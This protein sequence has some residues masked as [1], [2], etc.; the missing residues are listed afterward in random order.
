MELSERKIKI[1][2]IAVEEFIKDSAPITSG[3][4]LDRTSLDVSTATLR[5]ELNA[6]EAMGFL[7]QLHTS[8]GRVPTAQGY[9]FYVENLLKNIKATNGELEDVRK[10][11]ENRTQSLT[12]IVS[13]IAKIISKATNYPT[14]V[15]VNGIENL[16]LQEFKIIPLLDEKVMVLIGTNY[17]YITNTMDVKASAQNCED[18]SNYLTK[19][20]KGETMGFMLD[21]IDQ[22]KNGM[23]GEIEAFQG[24]VDNIIL[25]LSKMNKRKLLN[26]QAGG[27][28]DLVDNSK[29]EEAKKVLKTLSDENE[30][31]EV[32]DGDE[33]DISAVIAEDGEDKCS[34]VKAPIIVGGNKLASIGV[35][36][37]QK[38]D[39][40]GIASALKVV[41]DE[42]NKEKGE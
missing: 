10:L 3:R 20:F 1:L 6:L 31:I 41:V 8:G 34:V 19:Y 16:V 17:G 23:S 5:N 11:I 36:G 13:G 33:Q 27:M 29:V 38:M 9:R 25:G 40:M 28:V 4:V 39:Y 35:F 12:E 18:A 42:L 15:L 37:P 32:L 26:V 14:V 24:V 22:F 30:L 2:N 7:K 21:N